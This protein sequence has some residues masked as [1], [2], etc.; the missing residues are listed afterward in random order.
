MDST[1]KKEFKLRRDNLLKTIGNDGIAIVFSA[2]ECCEYHPY[3]QNSDFYYLT[4]FIEPE[5]VAV[6]IPGRC[7]SE[8]ILFNREHDPKKEIWHGAITG[9]KGACKDFGADQAFAISEID[10]VLPK[11]LASRKNIYSN[12]NASDKFDQKIAFWVK[13]IG[14][15]SHE[16]IS[17]NNILHEMRVKKSNF[18]LNAIRKAVEITTAGHLRA[19]QKCIPKIYEFELEAEIL[20]EF[21]RLG[22]CRPAFPTI[23]A[24]GI[25]ACTLHYSKNNKKITKKELILIDAGAR[26]QNYCADVSRTFPVNGKFTRKQQT[27]YEIVLNAQIETIKKIRPGVRWDHLQSTAEK[28][29]T[30]GLMDAKIL[31]GNIESLVTKQKFKPFFMHKIGHWLGLEPHDAGKY[32]IKNKWRTLEPGMVLTVEPGIYLKTLGMG[33]RIE[34][35][36]LVTSHGCEVLTSEIPKSVTEIEKIMGK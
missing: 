3:Q 24:S 28:V 5:S 25:N 8:F 6:L 16:L 33:I 11:L 27:C 30:K 10:K 9:Q 35:N 20:H 19:M 2:K 32:C 14:I 36:I 26:Y 31:H 12:T 34:D 29:I 1:Q 7:N 21:M 17:I 13:K 4:G 23:I 18:E 15:K 22:G